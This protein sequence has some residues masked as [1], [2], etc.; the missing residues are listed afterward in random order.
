MEGN[1]IV[2]RSL[3]LFSTARSVLDREFS[4]G[5]VLVK[6]DSE[7]GVEKSICLLMKL[8]EC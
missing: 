3:R 8:L 7:L 4:Q 2:D 1:A 6:K 5:K